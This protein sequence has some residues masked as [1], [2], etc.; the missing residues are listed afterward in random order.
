MF[1]TTIRLHLNQEP[2]LPLPNIP[3]CLYDRDETNPDDPLGM[4]VTDADGQAT[5][6]YS[7]SQLADDEDI[8]GTVDAL[9]EL[10]VAVYDS[11]GS[12]VL[13]TRA[14]AKRNLHIPLI[15]VSIAPQLALARGLVSATLAQASIRRRLQAHLPQLPYLF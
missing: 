5:I 7:L 14:N 10:Y 1:S 2:P 13:S 12:V 4:A 6:Y 9:P 8:P 15:E 11:H 3:V